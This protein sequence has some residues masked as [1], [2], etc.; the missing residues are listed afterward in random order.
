[1]PTSLFLP[2]DHIEYADDEAEAEANPGQDETV[3]L[4]AAGEK[5]PFAVGIV[6]SVD[7]HSNQDAQPCKQRKGELSWLA[8]RC[9][10]YDPIFLGSDEKVNSICVSLNSCSVGLPRFAPDG[11]LVNESYLGFPICSGLWVMKNKSWSIL[12]STC[13]FSSGPP[14]V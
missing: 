10:C 12:L 6:V 4:M 2:Q 8:L 13:L 3:A 14:Y 1:M 7:R 5:V 11:I 9:S